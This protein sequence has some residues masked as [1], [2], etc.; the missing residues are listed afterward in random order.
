MTRKGFAL[1]VATALVAAAPAWAG[2]GHI[3]HGFGATNSAMGGAGVALPNDAI[4]ALHLNPAL[5]TRLDGHR[6][7][8]SAEFADA[9]NA[10]ESS[11][12]TP[13]GTFSGRTEEGG[14][15][16]LIPAFGWTRNKTGNFAYGMGFIGLAGFGVDYPQDPSNP[17]LA[18]QPQGFGRVYSNYQLMKVPFAFAWRVSDALSVGLSINA[19]RSSLTANPAG[20]AAPD[21]TPTGT[22]FV[23]SVNGDSAFGFGASAGL[24][25]QINDA[26][27][28]GA[29]YTSEQDFE[30]FEFNS[31]RA[32]PARPDF[33]AA[34]TI[35]FQINS[36]AIAAVGF[37]IT[38]SDRLSIALDAKMISYDDTEGFGGSGTDASGNAIG[39]GWED[40]YVYALGVQFQATRSLTL[41]AGYNQ[42]ENP[43]P[44]QANFFN[45]TSPAIF[46]DHVTLGLGLQI[47]EVMQANLGVYRAFENRSTGN[48]V[49]PFGPVPGTQVTNEMTMDSGVLTFS[50]KL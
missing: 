41:R 44:P 18:P 1:A 46:E 7:E 5:L 48:F 23:P 26:F 9:Q 15:P 39:L 42:S 49:S 3:L 28:F 33:G 38:P 17:I 16:A 8:F 29:S 34:R 10:V 47:N 37:G 35:K 30:E 31:A 40:I 32:N 24:H 13:V 2:N 43:I 12:Q 14:D 20:F 25:Y 19:G 36:P 45:V 50:F 4:G 6:F 22:C 21:C 11:V 27:A